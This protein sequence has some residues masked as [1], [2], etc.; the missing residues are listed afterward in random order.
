VVNSISQLGTVALV[1][2]GIE[3]YR[4]RSNPTWNVVFWGIFCVEILWGAISGMKGSLF[5]NCM[6]VALVSSLIQ[7]KLNLRWLV[8]PFFGL[9]LLYPV[10]DAYR[11]LVRG[12][13]AEGVTSFAGAASTGR[14]AFQDATRETEG[15]GGLWQSG[16][17]H[18]LGRFDLL[19]S[20]AGIL[21]LG[22]RASMVKGDVHWWMLPIYPFV[23][24]FIWPS[25]PVLDEGG[26]F[27]MAL[28]GARSLSS[29]YAMG[30]SSTGVTYAGDLYLQFGLLGIPPGMFLLGLVAQLL[31]NRMSGPVERQAIFVYTGVF[32]FG[33]PLESDAFLVWASLI[34]LLAILYLMSW[35]IYGPRRRPPKPVASPP[36]MAR[37]L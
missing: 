5:Q 20:V 21:T 26:R 28:S 27:T 18:T 10:S 37:Q 29:D 12:R 19:T 24:R 30:V 25:K 17:E 15:G 23:P 35:I 16:L 36:V 2:A 31:S 7:R 8:L 14:M 13:G 33:F 11:G 34:K 1:V 6:V 3:K 22:P 32:L 9:I 4:K